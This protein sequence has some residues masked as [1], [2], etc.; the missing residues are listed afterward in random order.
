M[1]RR[2]YLLLVA[3]VI[4]WTSPTTRYED[5]NLVDVIVLGMSMISTPL[6]LAQWYET[7]LLFDDPKYERLYEA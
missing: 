6:R 2:T 3:V 7:L 4:T 5:K 1:T